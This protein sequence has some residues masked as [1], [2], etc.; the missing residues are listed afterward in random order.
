MQP[1]TRLAFATAACVFRLPAEAMKESFRTF[2]PKAPLTSLENK[3]LPLQQL[4]S[5]MIFL[6]DL[7]NLNVFNFFKKLKL[8]LLSEEH[9]ET[10]S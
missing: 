1:L 2:D 4:F 5:G 3:Q 7:K 8:Y 9:S 6:V 10:L